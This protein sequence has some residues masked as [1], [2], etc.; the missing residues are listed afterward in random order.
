VASLSVNKPSGPLVLN[1]ALQVT[2]SLHL[3]RGNINTDSNHILTF[4]GSKLQAGNNGFVAG[5]FRYSVN[6]AK[7]LQFPVGKSHYYAPV[8]LSKQNNDAALFQVEYHAMGHAF[9][10]SAMAFPLQSVSKSEYWSIKKIFPS[11]SLP[12][13][14]ILRLRLGMNSTNNIIGQPMLV[15][16]GSSAVRWELLPL[17]ANNTVSNTVASAPTIL[18]SG[19]YTFGSM[20]PSAL[21][22]ES[23]ELF[24][25]E[26]NGFT[27]LRWTT[28]K[29]ETVAQYVVE[30][31]NG[32]DPYAALDSIPS[33]NKL[34]KVSYSFDLRSSR[35]RGNLI[36]LRSVDKK[37]R[38]VYSNILYVRP[39]SETMRVF[40][41]PVSNILSI[42]PIKEPQ[43]MVQ[44]LG[45][46][47]QMIQTTPRVR[48]NQLEIDV[49][50]LE[51][52]SYYLMLI[53]DG[54][55]GVFPFIKQ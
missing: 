1:A 4:S 26:R 51:P 25:Q 39:T 35:I 11:D 10:D 13:T 22:K 29:D 48:E 20:F 28:D 34:G 49:R 27:R 33:K 17:Y 55:K 31:S 14:D 45:P 30:K 24:Q 18:A 3:D 46:L 19:I 44:L 54:K 53:V 5:P 40:P 9:P 41:N 6:V 38:T 8:I 47:G 2:D 36:R 16:K 21:P 12:S 23:L 52:G 42:G 32:D 7:D 50:K 37:G 15:R 43:A